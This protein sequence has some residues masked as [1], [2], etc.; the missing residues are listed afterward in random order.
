MTRGLFDSEH[1]DLLPGL[2]QLLLGPRVTMESGGASVVLLSSRVMVAALAPRSTTE[3]RTW[4][5]TD[6]DH[7]RECVTTADDR[8]LLEK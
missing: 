6:E 1:L 2:L 5:R 4:E 7:S 8:V 3:A